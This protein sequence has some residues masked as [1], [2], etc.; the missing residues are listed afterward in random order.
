M[1]T[2]ASQKDNLEALSISPE[3]FSTLKY[4]EEQHPDLSPANIDQILFAL[5]EQFSQ[6][7]SEEDSLIQTHQKDIMKT[8]LTN[9][10]TI[11]GNM[12]AHQQ[13]LDLQIHTK[14]V[15]PPFF[16]FFFSIRIFYY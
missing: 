1:D 7:K 10:D 4:F 13:Q 16:F 15:T 9:I 11:R 8:L 6:I 3:K 5:K 2:A 12:I 14:T